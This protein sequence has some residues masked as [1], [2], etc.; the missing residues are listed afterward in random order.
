LGVGQPLDRHV[1]A[2]GQKQKASS[3]AAGDGFVW[4]AGR[5]RAVTWSPLLERVD[6]VSVTLWVI[7]RVISSPKPEQKSAWG[8]FCLISQTSCQPERSEHRSVIGSYIQ[9]LRP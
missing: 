4:L 1:A 7:M 8:F 3:D 2:Q 6:L 9:L 5:A